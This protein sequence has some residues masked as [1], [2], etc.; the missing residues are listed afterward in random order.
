MMLLEAL[1]KFLKGGSDAIL[2][3]TKTVAS[4]VEEAVALPSELPAVPST[5]YMDLNNLPRALMGTQ[6][7]MTR[8]G[9]GSV[10]NFERP[11]LRNIL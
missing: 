10:P 2:E 9:K 3:P 5:S 8:L 4:I 1:K 11:Q 6:L 7:P